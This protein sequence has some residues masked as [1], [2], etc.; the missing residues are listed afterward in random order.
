VRASG[1]EL[2]ERERKEEESKGKK[3]VLCFFLLS[4]S[5][6]PKDELKPEYVLI[7]LRFMVRRLEGE[8]KIPSFFDHG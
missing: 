8:F 3:R 5:L 4:L 2:R 6:S 7:L 1:A